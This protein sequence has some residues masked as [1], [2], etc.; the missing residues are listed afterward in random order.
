MKT[1]MHGEINLG[2]ATAAKQYLRTHPEV[3]SI[4]RYWWS[5]SD[6]IECEDYSRDEMLLTQARRL[7]KGATVQWSQDHER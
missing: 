1:F 2:S 5:G 7:E 4:E 6:L 3:Q